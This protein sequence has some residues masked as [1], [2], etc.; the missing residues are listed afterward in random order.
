[1]SE[2][3]NLL[4]VCRERL[5]SDELPFIIY[6]TVSYVNIIFMSL[7]YTERRDVMWT[8]NGMKPDNDFYKKKLLAYDA[9]NQELMQENNDLRA[10]LRT[11]QEDMRGVLNAPNGSF[12][13]SLASNEKTD[14]DLS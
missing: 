7:V 2:I 3:M 11:T 10:L 6:A 8:W 12:K 5:L 13:P 9:K 4:Q 14:K 1:M